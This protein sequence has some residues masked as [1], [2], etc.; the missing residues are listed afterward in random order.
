MRVRPL[1]YMATTLLFLGAGTA[2]ADAGSVGA[3]VSD[4]HGSHFFYLARVLD[5]S[6]SY[7]LLLFDAHSD[8]APVEDYPAV[9]RMF[10]R[11]EGDPTGRVQCYNWIHGLTPAP[12]SGMTWIPS[13]SSAQIAQRVSG[14]FK[15]TVAGWFRQGSAAVLPFYRLADFMPTEKKIIVSIDL[16]FFVS[17]RRPER[18][19]KE[20][21]LFL[22]KLDNVAFIT[23]AISRPYLPDDE[24]ACRMLEAALAA[25]LEL[26]DVGEIEFHP[27]SGMSKDRSRRAARITASGF[28]VP[29]FTLH[30]APRSLKNLIIRNWKKF[31]FRNSAQARK[32]QAALGE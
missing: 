26:Q 11:R 1:R 7:H 2:L 15:R 3:F 29:R 12:I 17:S 22:G 10:F 4:N 21:F 24:F 25:L 16:D 20:I 31:I 18:D 32:V 9:R 6:S 8:T 28:S 27:F 13:Y 14:P 30:Q 5:P 23:I 19:L